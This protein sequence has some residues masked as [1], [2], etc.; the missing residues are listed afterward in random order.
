[1]DDSSDES[2]LTLFTPAT[3]LPARLQLNSPGHDTFISGQ[4]AAWRSVFLLTFLLFLLLF[5]LLEV[6][7]SGWLSVDLGPFF[8]GESLLLVLV[9]DG[10]ADEDAAG[11]DDGGHYY[12]YYLK[13]VVV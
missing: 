4:V 9:V 2:P 7:D 1:M 6:L 11:D 5:L 10:S 8:L 13:G 3:L 12:Y